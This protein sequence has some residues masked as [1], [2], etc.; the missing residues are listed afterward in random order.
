MFVVAV[1]DCGVLPA[2]RNGQVEMSG[3]SVADKASYS[4][5][6][7]FMLMGSR[8]RSCLDNGQWSETAPTC[9]SKLNG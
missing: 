7:G 6:S 8:M 9:E 2:P 3:T 4:C 5:N 1:V